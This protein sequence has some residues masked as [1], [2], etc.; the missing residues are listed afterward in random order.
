MD[1]V[2]DLGIKGMYDFSEITES[3]SEIDPQLLQKH[4]QEVEKYK[5]LVEE[6]WFCKQDKESIC[7]LFLRL[8][9]FARGSPNFGAS[10]GKFDLLPIFQ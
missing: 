8:V 6:L 10:E 5:K 1:F 3:L 4:L 9:F 2:Q 7:N